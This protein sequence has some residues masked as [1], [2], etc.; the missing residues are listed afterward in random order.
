MKHLIELG[1]LLELTV[2]E[3]TALTLA[4]KGG[5]LEC[6]QALVEAKADIKVIVDL[7]TP[8]EIAIYAGHDDIGQYLY[9]QAIKKETR[10]DTLRRWMGGPRK[11]DLMEWLVENKDPSFDYAV[12]YNNVELMKYFKLKLD[13]VGNVNAS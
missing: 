9:T 7:C 3:N 13:T 6:V 5:S 8:L 10:W 1:A 12:K 4:V 2:R 11:V